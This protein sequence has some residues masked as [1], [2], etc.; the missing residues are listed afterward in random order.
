[1]SL[2]LGKG[3]KPPSLTG[4]LHPS[5]QMP[6][7]APAPL[8]WNWNALSLW[9][10]V[11]NQSHPCRKR[12]EISYTNLTS[13]PSDIL[14]NSVFH[15]NTWALPSTSCY[16][17]SS[18]AQSE[19]QDRASPLEIMACIFNLG[20]PPSKYSTRQG[21]WIHCPFIAQTPQPLFTCLWISFIMRTSVSE[22]R[23]QR[24]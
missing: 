9:E 13:F 1:M 18:R 23:S 20:V 17:L 14:Q 15:L 7:S 19:L 12:K 6:D 21:W 2:F 10:N 5:L 3:K 24:S 8:Q 11:R 16:P 22:A 4:Y